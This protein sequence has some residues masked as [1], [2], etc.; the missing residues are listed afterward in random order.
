MGT[1]IDQYPAEFYRNW[2]GITIGVSEITDLFQPCYHLPN[3]VVYPQ[4]ENHVIKK[5]GAV[6]SYEYMNP[7]DTVTA[8][9]NG[10]LSK[11]GTCAAPAFCMAYHLGASEIYL[12]GV[13]LKAASDGR[14]YFDGCTKTPPAHYQLADGNDPEVQ[15]TIRCF[16]DAFDIY[17]AKGVGVY[18]LSLNTRLSN[19][20]TVNV[21]VNNA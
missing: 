18:N 2:P 9:K 19:I 16:S 12:I 6:I 21:K 11:R 13:D 17:R 4:H 10:K 1:S 15:A 8:E 3:V 20:E 5:D 14:I 7:S